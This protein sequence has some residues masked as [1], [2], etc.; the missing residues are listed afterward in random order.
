M[1]SQK[2]ENV[3]SSKQ[4]V[5]STLLLKFSCKYKKK[6]WGHREEG[7]KKGRENESG[8][9]GRRKKSRAKTNIS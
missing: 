7:R 9:E 5:P 1:I 8:R 3:W 4:V 2:K 6:E